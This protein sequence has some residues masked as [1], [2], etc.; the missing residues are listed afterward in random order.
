MAL[1]GGVIFQKKSLSV[2]VG[3]RMRIR[4]PPA[5]LSIMNQSTSFKL[6]DNCFSAVCIGRVLLFN[7]MVKID[8]ISIIPIAWIKDMLVGICKSQRS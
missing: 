8:L 3:N 7:R 5:V 1:I 4:A 2:C 6:E